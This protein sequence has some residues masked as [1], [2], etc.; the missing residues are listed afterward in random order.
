MTEMTDI[1]GVDPTQDALAR[2]IAAIVH[3]SGCGSGYPPRGMELAA[4]CPQRS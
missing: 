2:W 1:S 3:G 4:G